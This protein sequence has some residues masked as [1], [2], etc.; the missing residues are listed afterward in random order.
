MFKF[1]QK[2]KDKLN[3]AMLLQTMAKD[4]LQLRIKKKEQAIKRFLKNK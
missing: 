4:I 3:N 1:I 2:I